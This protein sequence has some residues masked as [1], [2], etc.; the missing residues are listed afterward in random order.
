[1]SSRRPRLPS[2]L[3]SLVLLGL[4]IVGWGLALRGLLLAADASISLLG[5]PL[6]GLGYD[7]HAYWLAGEGLRLGQSIY[8]ATGIE[9]L[10]AY[11]YPPPLA[12]AWA[13]LSLLD[14]VIGEWAWR[15]VGLLSIRYM[16]GTWLVSGLW[17]LYPGTIVELLAG[18]VTLPLA[19]LTVAAI[20]GRA[21][22]IGPAALVKLNPLVVVP[23]IWFCRPA[24]RRGLVVGGLIAVALLAT[25]VLLSPSAWSEYLG[26]L[27]SQAGLELSGTLTIHLLPTSGAD[28]TLRLLLVALLVAGSVWWRSAHV[29]YL[30]SV[31]AMPTLWFQHLSA[32]FA[33]LT[34]E[35]GSRLDRFAR[36][37]PA[38]LAGD[39]PEDADE[40]A[41]A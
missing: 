21:E 26:A 3:P 7:T 37:L 10:G 24:A 31:L 9:Q 25:S 6:G 35:E 18:N 41:T 13:P 28:F 5:Q 11:F 38:R 4:S 17:M 1:M 34:L 12:Q 30:A 8:W 2:R 36:A 16:A 23:F 33:L 27:G 29:A 14:P 20:R 22:G 15:I 40:G 32:L 39:R 19:A